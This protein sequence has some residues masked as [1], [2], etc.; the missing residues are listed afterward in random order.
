MD[1]FKLNRLVEKLPDDFCR[2][3]PVALGNLQFRRLAIVRHP[4][5]RNDDSKI[6]MKV[7]ESSKF[8]IVDWNAESER[9]SFLEK[10]E[11]IARN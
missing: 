7:L 6:G 3:P 2:F 10:R 8:K 4:E 1:Q 9:V 5:F 11:E